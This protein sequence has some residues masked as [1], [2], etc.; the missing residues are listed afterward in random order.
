MLNWLSRHIVRWHRGFSIHLHNA[1]RVFPSLIVLIQSHIPCRLIHYVDRL[2][3]NGSDFVINVTWHGIAYETSGLVQIDTPCKRK[4]VSMYSRLH[5]KCT[6]NYVDTTKELALE[7][8][9]VTYVYCLIWKC[10]QKCTYVCFT[11][12]RS[13]FQVFKPIC[14]SLFRTRVRLYNDF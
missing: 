3:T 12:I 13:L 4:G 9:H 2:H 1:L 8:I 11:P 10:K 6:R 7:L 14:F 5:L